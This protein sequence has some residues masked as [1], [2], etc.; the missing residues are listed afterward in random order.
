MFRKL[1]FALAAVG[2]LGAAALVP[3][4]ASMEQ[5]PGEVR[6]TKTARGWVAA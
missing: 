5:L 2:T 6:L 3:T 1:I 4:A